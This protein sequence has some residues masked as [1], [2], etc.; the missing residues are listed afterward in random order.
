ML[1]IIVNSHIILKRRKLHSW[2]FQ[3]IKYLAYYI[4]GFI[5]VINVK[6]YG[7]MFSF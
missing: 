4:H 3:I 5:Q 6:I 2:F 1:F 7:I